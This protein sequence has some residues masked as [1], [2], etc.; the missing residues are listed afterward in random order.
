MNTCTNEI[1]RIN[2]VLNRVYNANVIPYQYRNM[3]ASVY[4]YDYFSGSRED[5][6]ALALNT[7]VLEQIKERL[8]VIIEQQSEMILNQRIMIAKQ[9]KTIQL[10][11]AHTAMMQ[12]KL[13]QIV[14]SNEERNQYL[15]MI[16]GNTAATAYFAAADYIR[17]I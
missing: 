16:E 11:Q 7:F 9:E 12:N 15:R 8:D 3:Y 17:R 4:L 1:N 10:Q 2:T 14:A 13:N 5:D 6:L